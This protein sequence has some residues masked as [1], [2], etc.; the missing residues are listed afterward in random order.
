MK[1]FLL[2]VALGAITVYLWGSFSWIVLPWH[3]AVMPNLPND[4][5]VIRVL[6]QNISQT[7]VYRFP[8]YPM[9]G[10]EESMRFFLQRFEAGPVGMI[11]YRQVGYNPMS[12]GSFLWGFFLD[13]CAVSLVV[14]LLWIARDRVRGYTGR[15]F[16]VFLLGL[17][18]SLVSHG[19]DMAWRQF[20]PAWTIVR[21]VDLVAAWL[22]GGLVIGAVLK[23]P[24]EA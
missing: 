9:D 15:V 12:A 7:G 4:T 23:P 18:A 20:P 11:V 2:A 6:N 1:R 17:F 14:V 8:S 16:F 21:A 10:S 22:I 3:N 19:S 13:I 24:P 5:A